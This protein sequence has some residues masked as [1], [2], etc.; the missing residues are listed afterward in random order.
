[1]R[2]G[3]VNVNKPSGVSSGYAVNRIKKLA[4]LSCGHM[5]TLDPLASGVLPVALGN[6]ARLF[7]Y[8]LEKRKRYVAV[9]RF[10]VMSD[11][12]DSTGQLDFSNPFVPSEEALKEAVHAQ[13]GEIMQV[14]PR[15]S[16]KSVN[17][18]R[19]YALARQGKEFSLSAKAVSVGEFKLLGRVDKDIFRFEIECGGGT[20]IR[21]LARDLAVSLG[22]CAAMSA[23][24]RT[25]SGG[26]KIENSIETRALTRDNINEYLIPT[27]SVLPYPKITLT[28]SECRRYLNGLAVNTE[29]EAGQYRVYLAEGSFYGVGVSDGTILKSRLKLC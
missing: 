13:I 4:G 10:G 5:G 2:T 11:T 19:G 23:L 7:D 9:F 3:F 17:G 12:L 22:T 6:A 15:Y 16:A 26:F 18:V 20:Y 1:M 24:C 21:S 8:M 28:S 27:D 25:E 29:L 14:P